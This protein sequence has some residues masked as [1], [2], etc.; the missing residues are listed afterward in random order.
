MTK[1]TISDIRD[2]RDVTEIINSLTDSEKAQAYAL[3]KGM[4]I[5]KKLAETSTADRST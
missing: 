2:T 3:L 4:I 1:Q 5:G